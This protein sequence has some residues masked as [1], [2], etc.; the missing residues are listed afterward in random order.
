MTYRIFFH[1][2]VLLLIATVLSIESQP[3]LA[4]TP[5]KRSIR[6]FFAEV[7]VYSV[8][9]GEGIDSIDGRFSGGGVGPGGTFGTSIMQG[10]REIELKLQS[11]LKEGRFIV[12]FTAAEVVGEKKRELLALTNDF[13]LTDMVT[14]TI[15]LAKDTGGRVYQLRLVPKVIESPL[16][17]RFDAKELRLEHFSFNNSK[18]IL[19]DQEYLGTM[20]MFSGVLVFVDIPG[21]AKIEFSLIP[22]KGSSEQ[23][24]LQ[25]GTIKIHHE[26]RSL[27]IL[28]VRNG[29]RASELQGGPY[30]LFV[31][32]SPPTYSAEESHLMSKRQ[33]DDL[34]TQLKNGEGNVT[35]EKLRFLEQSAEK[36]RV[37]MNYGLGPISA[38][39]K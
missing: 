13:D 26:G 22:F 10:E 27:E 24:Q 5:A 15:E 19:D 17:N 32:W 2:R 36:R 35:E 20:S 9:P 33:L 18:V 21:M 39:D 11:L 37:F 1:L 29:V 14:K 31:R 7:E 34:R 12:K 23:G 3:A 28:R 8:M 16:A 25:N 38:K 30:S 4:Q 6:H